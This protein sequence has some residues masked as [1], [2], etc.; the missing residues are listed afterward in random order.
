MQ[1]WAKTEPRCSRGPP[2]RAC[3]RASVFLMPQSAQN[4]PQ[5]EPKWSPNLRKC[6]KKTSTK[7]GQFP[8]T[9]CWWILLCLELFL[10]RFLDPLDPWFRASRVGKTLI[11]TFSTFRNRP[12][13]KVSQKMLRKYKCSWIW[14]AFLESKSAKNA[15]KTCSKKKT[16]QTRK[17]CEK[18]PP[19]GGEPKVRWPPR[20]P[21][22][23]R[24]D[25][26]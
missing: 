21:L 10:D 23:S 20:T 2:R 12:Q 22:C 24:T 9:V 3:E 1:N 25:R 18:E 19:K 13:N 6:E 4:W 15:A 7:T 11:F 16:K 17:Q 5:K 14:G 26:Y 8:D